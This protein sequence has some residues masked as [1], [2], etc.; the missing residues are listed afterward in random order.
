MKVLIVNYSDIS[1]GAARAA[2]RLHESLLESNIDSKMLVVN[3]VIHGRFVHGPGT[4]CDLYKGKLRL[5]LDSLLLKIYK[6][7]SKTMFSP[8]IMPYS[9]I[10]KKINSYNADI[11]HLHWV[12]NAMISIN[13]IK[14]INAPIVWSLHDMWPFTGG[15][16]YS[17]GCLSYQNSCGACKVL[18]SKKSYDLS[19]LLFNKKIK[20]FSKKKMVINGLSS[21][22]ARAAS[23]SSIFQGHI[24]TNL[25]NMIDTK[26]F[27]P[28]NT[29]IARD[30]LN[31][32]K[33]QKIIMF[34]A[35]SPESDPR[36]RYKE[37]TGALELLE[38]KDVE[39]AI[40]GAS[41]GESN[42][43]FK[44]HYLGFINDD[45]SLKLLYSSADVLVVP[46]LEENLSNIIMESLSCGTP[47]VGFDI[48]GNSDMVK[49]KQN[50]YLA[51]PRSHADM[52]NG[53]NWVIDNS[54]N[55]NIRDISRNIC[56]EKFGSATAIKG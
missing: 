11:V 23:E 28:I 49:H 14:Y 7:R 52:V 1:G 13:D 5:Y 34:G 24:I 35:M 36:K 19:R 53:I 33:N 48:G 25:P 10:V 15:C 16:H 41:H 18:R 8:S 22:I 50:G 9:G 54:K 47:V 20:S 39:L 40:F 55:K 46:S 4:K 38:R 27:S 43:R 21:W 56:V 12:C 44:T 26:V 42:N 17:E 31:L 29:N 45:I 51:R 2:N 37:L 30:I 6:N 32:P 3:K